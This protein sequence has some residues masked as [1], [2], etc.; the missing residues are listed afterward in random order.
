MVHRQEIT[1]SQATQGSVI[2]RISLNKS[3]LYWMADNKALRLS[4]SSLRKENSKRTIALTPISAFSGSNR[5]K[6]VL[7]GNL[8]RIML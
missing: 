1:Y 4:N 7:P 6:C 3:A 5:P 2:N 8:W